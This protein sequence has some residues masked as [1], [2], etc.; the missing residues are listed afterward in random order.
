MERGVHR[1]PPLR[2]H[3][4]V[5]DQPRSGVPREG[6][7]QAPGGQGPGVEELDHLVHRGGSRAHHGHGDAGGQPE[8]RQAR[9]RGQHPSRDL[10]QASSHLG[11][12]PDGIQAGCSPGQEGRGHQH[13]GRPQE[14]RA[15]GGLGGG[16][17]GRACQARALRVQEPV[18]GKEAGRQEGE[19][20]QAA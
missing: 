6:K 15:P 20:R 2:R 11:Q 4:P 17:G 1:G 19:P 16:P 13:H 5:L 8:G 12:E 9:K 14:P 10:L 3:H 18:Q 7:G